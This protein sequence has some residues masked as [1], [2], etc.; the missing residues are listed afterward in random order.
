MPTRVYIDSNTREVGAHINQARVRN[1][2]AFVVIKADKESSFGAM[3]GIMKT[4]Q[5]QQLTRFQIITN[6]ETEV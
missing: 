2:R 4:L 6:L 1:P 3:E 5:E